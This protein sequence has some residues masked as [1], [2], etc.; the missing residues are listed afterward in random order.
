MSNVA[1]AILTLESCIKS[2]SPIDTYTADN[3][4]QVSYSGPFCS[5]TEV[6]KTDGQRQSIIKSAF[7]KDKK[8]QKTNTIQTTKKSKQKNE[9]HFF[10]Y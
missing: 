4:T 10:L 8:Q 9:R 7:C 1:L 3:K 6:E 5:W 2:Q